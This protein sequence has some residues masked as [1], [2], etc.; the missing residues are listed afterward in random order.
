VAQEE[1]HRATLVGSEES[2]ALFG[3]CLQ[4]VSIA[5]DDFVDIGTR[6]LEDQRHCL[7][8]EELRRRWS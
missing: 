4:A 5:G 1:E 2:L 3:L 7:G 8:D 6:Y